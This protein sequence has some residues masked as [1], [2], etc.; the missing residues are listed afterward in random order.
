MIAGIDLGIST[1]KFALLDQNGV[2][3]FHTMK[4]EPMSIEKLEWYIETMMALGR[5]DIDTVAVTGVGAKKIGDTLYKKPV[6]HVDEFEANS[7]SAQSIIDKDR[8]IIASMGTG[9]S[10]VLAENGTYTHIGGSA[11]GGGTLQGMMNLLM[12]GTNFYEFRELAKKG[13]LSNIDLQI[14][15]VSPVALPN[16]PMDTTAANFAK[17][18]EAPAKEDLAAG[19]VNLILQNV[20]VM[21]NLAGKGRGIDTFCF[22]GLMCTLPK[23]RDIFDRLEQLYGIHIVVPEH[24]ETFTALGAALKARQL[25]Q[26][27]T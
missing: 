8:F 11:L 20:G 16:L 24:P 21:A 14:K 23:S 7:L 19:L 17:V 18:K 3:V 10:F 12:Q 5:Y 4:P 22:I 1:T 2:A 26:I 25:L 9:T 13:D 15:D 6:I 27:K